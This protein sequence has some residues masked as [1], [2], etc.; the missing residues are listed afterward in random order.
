[1]LVFAL[2]L[3]LAPAAP[4]AAPIAPAALVQQDTGPGKSA[5][6]K[7]VTE[8]RMAFKGKDPVARINALRRAIDVP[9]ADVVKAVEPALKSDQDDVLRA[10]IETL[11]R[12]QHEQALE[13]LLQYAK[14]QKKSLQKLPELNILLVKSIGRHGSLKA[15]G[16]LTDK[17]FSER[18]TTVIKAR[19]VALGKIRDRT[20]VNALFAQL[21]T[22]DRR[23]ITTVMRSVQIALARLTG[24]DEGT[25]QDR[26]QAWWRGVPKDWVVSTKPAP[27]P[28]QLQRSWDG[29]WGNQR[30]YMRKKPRD[31]R[32][33]DGETD[34][35]PAPA[36]SA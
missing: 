17:L 20:A 26:W 3:L 4:A 13:R 15:L 32:G 23:R 9:H 35:T 34:G 19:I 10:G 28:E 25:G 21:K 16:Y 31:E 11:G 5:V 18:E 1:M 27:M 36:H 8:L 24:R 14:R 22:A 2:S 12:M 29:Y 30:K 33:Q 7:T 6:T